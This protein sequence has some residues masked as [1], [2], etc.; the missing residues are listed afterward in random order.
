[1]ERQATCPG[2]DGY[3]LQVLAKRELGLSQ[4]KGSDPQEQQ[5]SRVREQLR[6]S[7]PSVSIGVQ[8]HNRKHLCRLGQGGYRKGQAG[9]KS[10]TCA[11]FPETDRS[12]SCPTCPLFVGWICIFRPQDQSFCLGSKVLARPLKRLAAPSQH[13]PTSVSLTA[14]CI[15][16]HRNSP[17]VSQPCFPGCTAR[18]SLAKQAQSSRFKSV[19]PLFARQKSGLQA[20]FTL[21]AGL[22]KASRHAPCPLSGS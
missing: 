21:F 14:E 16:R 15:A 12:G 20:D 19:S 13:G 2:D 17:E 6:R 9:G 7:C 5:K 4:K 18:R 10:S 3:S 8:A 1:M 11:V 22:H